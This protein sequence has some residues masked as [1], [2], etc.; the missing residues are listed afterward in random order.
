VRS[1]VDWD[2]LERQAASPDCLESLLYGFELFI[3]LWQ[4]MIFAEALRLCL[5]H[6]CHD[7]LPV[8]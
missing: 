5:I 6:A 1:Q 2:A 8:P 7:F 4:K 3:F